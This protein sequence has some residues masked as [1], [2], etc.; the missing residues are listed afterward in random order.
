MNSTQWVTLTGFVKYLG[1]TGKCKVEETF[2]GL[3]KE[4]AIK[5]F[6]RLLNMKICSKLSSDR[7][8]Y[9]NIEHFYRDLQ[10]P[11][12]EETCPITVGRD[13]ENVFG[14]TE[15]AK[16]GTV[17]FL[18]EIEN[19][20]AIKIGTKEVGRHWLD[21]YVALETVSNLWEAK[22]LDMQQQM[23]SSS[24]GIVLATEMTVIV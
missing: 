8:S 16:I 4:Y 21:F 23:P 18:L 15:K 19:R 14:M 7:N 12:F 24:H 20:R 22:L 17:D 10:V 1:K 9:Q 3:R 5:G 6:C 2:K 13:I 11:L